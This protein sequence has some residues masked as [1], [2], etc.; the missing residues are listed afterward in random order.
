[1]TDARS[2]LAAKRGEA[3][4]SGP[5]GLAVILVL[6]IACYFLFKS[7]SK[8]LRKVRDEFPDDLPPEPL[9]PTSPEPREPAEPLEPT[10]P[11]N[12]ERDAPGRD[13]SGASERG[14]DQQL[15]VAVG[16]R[17]ALAVLGRLSRGSR[18][19][20]LMPSSR[21]SAASSSGVARR[22]PDHVRRRGVVDDRAEDR[23]RPVAVVDELDDPGLLRPV[24][25][26][27]GVDLPEPAAHRR[28]GRARVRGD[29]CCGACARSPRATTFG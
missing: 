26:R 14:A 20:S 16:H 3:A 23:Q 13:R 25:V 1:M 21:D 28:A 15:D 11:P 22:W 2:L 17:A 10:S 5:I 6:C 9:E 29:R 7:M 27:G 8:H 18:C 4:K 12:P 19:Q 24:D